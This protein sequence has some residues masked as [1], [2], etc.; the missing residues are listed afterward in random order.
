MRSRIGELEGLVRELMRRSG[1]D[2]EGV[3]VMLPPVVGSGMEMGRV[4]AS[5]SSGTSDSV[6]EHLA[7]TTGLGQ[8]RMAN[9]ATRYNGSSHWETVLA[10]VRALQA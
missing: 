3:A 5:S 1:T 9:G 7:I 2:G 6:D 8:L 4:S 10:T